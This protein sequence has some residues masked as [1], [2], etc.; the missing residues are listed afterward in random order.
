MNDDITMSPCPACGGRGTT[1]ATE[2]VM[3]A[4][5][6]FGLITIDVKILANLLPCMVCHGARTLPKLEADWLTQR[7]E[8]I[9]KRYHVR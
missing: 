2:N 5:D 8:D 3:S 6:E 9:D 1:N 4:P 7:F